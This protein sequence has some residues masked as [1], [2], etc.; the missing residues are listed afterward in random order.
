VDAAPHRWFATTV[1]LLSLVAALPGCRCNSPRDSTPA[2][3]A[4]DKP[5]ARATAPAS[6]PKAVAAAVPLPKSAT[7][8]TPPAAV[9]ATA[10]DLAVRR[11]LARGTELRGLDDAGPLLVR[12]RRWLRT[13]LPAFA[14]GGGAGLRR[15]GGAGQRLERFTLDDDA[16]AR[17]E[18]PEAGLQYVAESGRCTARMAAV[19]AT[20]PLE[21]TGSVRTLAAIALLAGNKGASGSPLGPKNVAFGPHPIASP[22][23]A[24]GGNGERADAGLVVEALHGGGDRPARL[25]MSS[26]ALS[27]RFTLTIETTTGRVLAVHDHIA[28]RPITLGIEAGSPAV[29]SLRVGERMAATWAVGEQNTA[30]TGTQDEVLLQTPVASLAEAEP[31]VARLATLAEALGGQTTGPEAVVVRWQGGKLSVSAVQSPALLPP[32]AQHAA[33]RRLTSHAQP[34]LPL[35][36]VDGQIAAAMAAVKLSPGC[37][38]VVVLGTP[39][40]GGERDAVAALRPCAPTK[41]GDEAAP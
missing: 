22:P 9:S 29:L 8:A 28:G 39:E 19:R 3:P 38:R 15:R 26:S 33:I 41:K 1:A 2:S 12:A 6:A 13:A 25:R 27:S 20:C 14:D 32:K 16:V 30:A 17:L 34:A 11:P 37:Y 4:A 23:L 24:A 31:A 10:P 36:F 5:A 40:G 7:P 18:R 35:R 21:A